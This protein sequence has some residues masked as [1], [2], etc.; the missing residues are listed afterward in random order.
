MDE[1]VDQVC[2]LFDEL[3]PWDK[4]FITSGDT[5]VLAGIKWDFEQRE[6]DRVVFLSVQDVLNGHLRGRLGR[7][8]IFDD[9][10]LSKKNRRL[11]RKEQWILKCGMG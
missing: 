11:I 6:I 7:L 4:I 10:A 1:I 2:M 8:I 9:W 5:D 3:S